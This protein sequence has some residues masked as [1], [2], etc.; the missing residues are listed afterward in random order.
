M[1]VGIDVEVVND[2]EGWSSCKWGNRRMYGHS[3]LPVVE[4]TTTLCY[5]VVF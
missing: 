5:F 2:E 3:E 1:S 4:W